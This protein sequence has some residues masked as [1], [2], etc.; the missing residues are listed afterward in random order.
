MTSIAHGLLVG[1]QNSVKLPSPR[2]DD[3]TRREI[4][5]FVHGLPN[6][7]RTLVHL[8]SARDER[9][10]QRAEIVIAFGSDSTMA[11]LRAQLHAD[12][13][14]I[15]HGHAVSLLWIDQPAAS[16]GG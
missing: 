3:A 15:A 13:K 7:L 16:H 1:A 9:S 2:E 6:P 14:F 11:A 8:Q 10:M 5:A 4:T 12:Q